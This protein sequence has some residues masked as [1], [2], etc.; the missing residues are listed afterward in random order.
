MRPPERA[1][2][3]VNENIVARVYLWR[4]DREISCGAARRYRDVSW[5]DYLSFLPPI[6]PVRCPTRCPWPSERQ[7]ARRC[8][9]TAGDAAIGER[10]GSKTRRGGG[11]SRRHEIQPIL[12]SAVSF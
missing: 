1:V 10:Q 8:A 2:T 11:T 5:S 7:R 9:A 4:R 12:R 6:P 3:S